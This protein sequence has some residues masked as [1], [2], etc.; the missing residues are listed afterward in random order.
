MYEAKRQLDVHLSAA[1]E[2]LAA[3]LH[4]KQVGQQEDVVADP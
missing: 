2:H 1:F 4:T 3:M